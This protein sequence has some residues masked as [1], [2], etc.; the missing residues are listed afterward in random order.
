MTANRWLAEERGLDEQTIDRIDFI[1]AMIDSLI[2]CNIG[3]EF[4]ESVYNEIESLE[5]ILQ[6]CWGFN[7]D[8]GHHT[9]KRI[10]KF[11]N[12]WV[13]RT[14]RCCS[15]EV[16]FTI[17][18]EVQERD[19]YSIGESFIDVGRLDGYWRSGG[20]LEEVTNEIQTTD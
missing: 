14:F 10:Y 5:Y 13:G 17:P 12:E 20:K 7:K 11:K 19:F 2:K 6:E 16:E 1:H 3:K 18:F 9:W 15:T 8:C 4:S